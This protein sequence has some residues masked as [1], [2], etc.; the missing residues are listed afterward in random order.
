VIGFRALRGGYDVSPNQRGVFQSERDAIVFLGLL[1]HMHVNWDP[2]LKTLD[3]KLMSQYHGYNIHAVILD[4]TDGEVLA[5]ERNLIH[6]FE[7]PVDHGE[8]LAVRAAVERL[9]VKRPRSNAQAVEEYYRSSLFYDQGSK[10]EDFLNKGCSLYTTLEP[11]PMCTATLLVCRMKRVIYVTADSKYGGS[12]NA[13][14]LPSGGIACKDGGVATKGNAR[15]RCTGLHDAYYSAYEQEYEEL[16]LD[17]AI[18]AL[19]EVRSLLQ[20]I[21]KRITTLESDGQPGTQFFDYL[22]PQLSEA[23]EQFN[24]F[25]PSQLSTTGAD[26]KRNTRTLNELKK[27]SNILY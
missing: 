18:G 12:W 5:L 24:S 1:S 4:N 9:R 11:C 27:L 6:E 10:P 23:Y 8:Q 26:L 13:R 15:C 21:R 14:P 20:R 17:G 25:Q 2:P 16:D 3:P 19:K 22:E 7:S